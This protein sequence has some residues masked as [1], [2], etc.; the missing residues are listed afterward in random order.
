MSGLSWITVIAAGSAVAILGVY[1]LKRPPLSIAWRLLLF[2]AIAAL[3]T[4]AAGTSTVS[5]LEKTTHREFCGSCHV[6]DAHFTDATD[7]QSQSLAARHT[8]NAMFGDKSCYKCHAN[9]GMYGYVLTK[10]DGMGHVRHYYFGEYGDLTLDEAVKK[11]HIKK[12]FPNSTCLE[13]HAGTGKLW[14]A[15][16]DHRAAAEAALSGR[17]S[18]SSVGCHG[19]AHP[20]SKAAHQKGAHS[21]LV[22]SPAAHG[23]EPPP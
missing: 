18:C 22:P 12:P 15:V 10:L 3:P 14:Q 13:C 1:W 21:H 7:P 4:L 16:P 5:S 23:S 6:M 9:Y 8:R 2:V 11:I 19:A 17:V 20:F